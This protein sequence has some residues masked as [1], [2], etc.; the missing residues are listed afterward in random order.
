MTTMVDE[1]LHQLYQDYLNQMADHFQD[2]VALT[3]GEWV[4]L[5]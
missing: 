5:D 4:E 2:D 3:F 1:L